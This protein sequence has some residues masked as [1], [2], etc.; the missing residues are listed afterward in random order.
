MGCAPF[1]RE[2]GSLSGGQPL[3]LYPGSAFPRTALLLKSGTLLSLT[4]S[5][6]SI[7]GRPDFRPELGIHSDAWVTWVRTGTAPRGMI[8]AGQ[9]S[10]AQLV[11]SAGQR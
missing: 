1:Y 5:Q 3:S 2:S 9:P 11:Q 7:L 6:V 10:R 8:A 4:S